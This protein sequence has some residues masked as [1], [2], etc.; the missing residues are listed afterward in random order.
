MLLL[1]DAVIVQ[2]AD[3]AR[4]GQQI[5]ELT[6]YYLNRAFFSAISTDVFWR[7]LWNT[8]IIAVGS[9]A[10]ALVTGIPL[11]WLLSRTNLP[12]K[13]WFSTALIVPYMLPSWTFAFGLADP[14]Q[15]PHHR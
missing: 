4:S 15:K 10:F 8:A 6:F 9:I 2:F 12:G 14:V 7:P 5:G 11:A 3:R 1:S 13:K